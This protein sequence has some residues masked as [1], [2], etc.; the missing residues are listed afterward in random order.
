MTK[1][2]FGGNIMLKKVANTV[3]GLSAD[4]VERAESGH[5]GMPIGC[6]E[7]GV[8]LFGEI[9][10]H[11][12]ADPEWPDR[13]RFVLSAGHGSML[14]Y[15]LLHLSGYDLS[16]EDLKNFRQLDSKTPG[17]PEYKETPGVETTTGPLGQGLSNAVGMALSERKMADIY[18]TE[19]KDIVDHYTYVIAGDGDMMEGVTS[20]ASSLA[21][22]LGLGKLIV[23]YD[24]NQISI[25]GDTDLAFT[26]SVADRYKAYDWHVIEDV[27][28]HDV[29]Q[30]KEAVKE[31]KM[32]KD[33]PTLIM[34]Q[35]HI[36]HGAPN[37]QDKSAAHG[38]PL[39]EEE[40]K[41]LKEYYGLP[42]N[43]KFYV[44]EEVRE[45][46]AA[47]KTEL[48]K[49]RK[50]WEERF[51]EWSEENPELKEKW[52]DAY[53]L[54]LPENIKEVV[55]NV[56]ID[57]P[58]ATRKASGASLREI[59][60]HIPYLFGGSA[61]L[62]PSN[63]T[64]LDKYEEIQK[65]NYGGRNIRFGVR[66]HAMGAIANGITCH[67]GLRPYVATFLV[68]SDYMRPSMRMAALMEQPVIYVF[69]HDSIYIGEDGPT[70]QPVEQV[71][72]LRLIPNLKVL[73][74]AD[75]EEAKQSWLEALENTSG[76]TALILTRQNLPHIEKD[77]GLDGFAK[78]GYV[79]SESNEKPRVVLM[80]SG[81]EVSLACEVK[82]L[83]K[84]EGHSGRIISVP[85]KDKFANDDTSYRDELLGDEDVLHVAM[86]AGRGQG[87]YQLLGENNMLITVEEFG[88]S[89]PGKEVA[90]DY[91][92][93][94]SKIADKILNRL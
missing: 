89:A 56:E 46:F 74:P 63:K 17:H 73:R 68:F 45:Y 4:G 42:V 53:N 51:K 40:V 13:D 80:A 12:P 79:V 26:E 23:F 54:K 57:T 10:K 36:A 22:H 44:P 9:M 83:L 72:S 20:E 85:E 25:A 88:K 55:S 19:D 69:T 43:K 66:E 33:R 14:L 39:G 87:W 86:E 90:R 21:G 61:D 7:I 16:L 62:A 3:K 2:T 34:A 59:A 70:H 93:S 65:G 8:A 49:E 37:K 58:I 75:E 29:D 81:S 1:N 6:A 5:P 82:E 50:Q 32:E 11:D 60:D 77:N 47:K 91:G 71:E 67:E 84:E 92:F 78:G 15:S 48:A 94:A 52:D 31:A 24:D 18:N 30:I 76:P 41:G 38:A 64:Y 27:D 35:T 28:G